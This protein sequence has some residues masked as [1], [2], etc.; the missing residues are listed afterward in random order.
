MKSKWASYLGLLLPSAASFAAGVASGTISAVTVSG[1]ADWLSKNSETIAVVGIVVA[2]ASAL[3]SLVWLHNLHAG[4]NNHH[5]V[6][7]KM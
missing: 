4:K 1:T 7:T 3:I 5:T 2:S 6:M